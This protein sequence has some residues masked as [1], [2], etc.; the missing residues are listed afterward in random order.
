MMGFGFGMGGGGGLFM[1]VFWVAVLAGV[2]F[3][4]RALVRSGSRGEGSRREETA[5]EILKKRYAGGEI[6]REE[7]EEKRRRIA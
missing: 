3:L 1:V 6:S 5:D 7:F 4:V 2:F